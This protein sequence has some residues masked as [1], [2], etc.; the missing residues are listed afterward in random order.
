MQTHYT[1]VAEYDIG[2]PI[3]HVVRVDTTDDE[4][5]DRAIAWRRLF[6]RLASH[7]HDRNRHSL[8]R[9]ASVD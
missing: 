3:T 5:S 1:F 9:V 8:L 7:Q 2:D 4:S 6:H